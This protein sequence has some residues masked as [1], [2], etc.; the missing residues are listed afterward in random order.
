MFVKVKANKNA[1]TCVAYPTLPDHAHGPWERCG[2]VAGTKHHYDVQPCTL[3]SQTMRT[4][5]ATAVLPC[6]LV[7]KEK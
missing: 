2:N 3:L 5:P 7:A 1:R 4:S 6:Y